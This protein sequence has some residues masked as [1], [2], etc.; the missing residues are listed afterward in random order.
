MPSARWPVMRYSTDAPNAVATRSRLSVLRFRFPV[1]TSLRKLYS[2]AL[3]REI[4]LCPA[5]GLA[6]F[7]IRAPISSS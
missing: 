7:R 4:I 5:L 6:D 2:F 1:S 3:P